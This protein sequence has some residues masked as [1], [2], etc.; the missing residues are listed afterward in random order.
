MDTPSKQPATPR[1]QVVDGLDINPGGQKGRDP[2]RNP[3]GQMGQ[4]RPPEEQA[5]QSD[6]TSAV[7]TDKRKAD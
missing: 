3:G 4:G 5:R 7:Q 2:R 6:R 1:D